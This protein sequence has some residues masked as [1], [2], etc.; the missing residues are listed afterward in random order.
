MG[1]YFSAAL[2][3]RQIQVRVENQLSKVIASC[4]RAKKEGEAVWNALLECPRTETVQ[5]A[6]ANLGRGLTDIQTQLT[7][8]EGMLARVKQDEIEA[9]FKQAATSLQ[10]LLELVEIA[11][12]LVQLNKNEC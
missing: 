4:K 7:L 3:D 2:H 6:R 12:S 9:D 11:N 10:N 8:F 1:W 5:A